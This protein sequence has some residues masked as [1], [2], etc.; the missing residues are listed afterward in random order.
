[1][2]RSRRGVAPPLVEYDVAQLYGLVTSAVDGIVYLALACGGEKS[3]DWR[4]NAPGFR[5]ARSCPTEDVGLA[6]LP[7]FAG[8][9]VLP[10]SDFSPGCGRPVVLYELR[11]VLGAV[12]EDFEVFVWQRDRVGVAR[13]CPRWR[14][15][16]RIF[17]R[18]TTR[19]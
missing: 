12:D 14:S 16:V 17:C 7:Y 11:L 3:V 13:R 9:Y 8:T 4:V 15:V 2:V 19:L 1:M 10:G 6:V 5:P 18:C